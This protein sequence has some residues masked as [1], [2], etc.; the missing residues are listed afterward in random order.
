MRTLH[1][2]VSREKLLSRLFGLF[3]Y[4]DYDDNGEAEL[5]K[6]TDSVNGCYGK[7]VENIILPNSYTIVI[8]ETEINLEEGKSYTYRTL[9]DYYYACLE[10]EESTLTEDD[11]SQNA[12]FIAFMEQGIGKREIPEDRFPTN[13]YDLVP[14]SIFIVTARSRYEEMYKLKV[15]C[16]A[17]DKGLEN[18]MTPNSHICCDCD[19]YERMGGD[20]ML[21]FLLE[22]M[23]DA[24]EVAKEYLSY[25]DDGGLHLNFSIPLTC[26]NNDLG[27]L[28]EYI[29]EWE[30][31]EQYNV[32]DLVFYDENSYV[33]IKATTGYWDEENEELIFPDDC[34]TLIKNSASGLP[35]PSDTLEYERYASQGADN[36]GQNYY[37]DK[38][39]LTAGDTSAAEE[40]GNTTTDV[41]YGIDGTTD[42]K[43]KS[44]RRYKEYTDAVGNILKPDDGYNW[45]YYYKVGMVNDYETINDDLGN[46]MFFTDK[47]DD[48]ILDLLNEECSDLY[49]YGNVITSI[50]IPED[51][52]K[53][54]VYK[55]VIEYYMG[56]HLK[57][58]MVK[59]ETDDDGNLHYYFDDFVM[60]ESDKYHG[61]KYTDTYYFD[62][63]GEIASDFLTYDENGT[64]TGVDSEKLSDYVQDVNDI[65]ATTTTSTDENG[66]TVTVTSNGR[67]PKYEFI[68]YNSTQSYEQNVNGEDVTITSIISEFDA[69][70]ENKVD[71]QYNRIFRVDYNNGLT[72][73]PVTDIDVSIDRG[74]TAAMEKHIKFGEIKT[75]DDMLLYANGS[76]FPIVSS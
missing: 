64:V 31:G 55:L 18:G 20:D 46:I 16:D 9:I 17:Y 4:V 56:V 32:G 71:Y 22:C 57:A 26:T 65:I 12:K 13:T 21:K 38:F 52:A 39:A 11:E 29:D 10:E 5:H 33:C 75:L 34:F 59:A 72:Y 53:E 41:D 15:L 2:E 24:E 60:D 61:V 1:Y 27:L 40:G 44:L 63:D 45:L 68:T 35:I 25:A 19:R 23:E 6:A 69:T 58:T 7:V 42:S 30:A 36:Y 28:T 66:E 49:A 3:A 50:T 51:E 54:G 74:N 47:T 76:F 37:G 70:I 62:P 73:E 8:D 67:N 48:D 14:S 43:L